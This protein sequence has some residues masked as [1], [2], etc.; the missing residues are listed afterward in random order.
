M[1]YTYPT[2]YSGWNVEEVAAMERVISSEQFTMGPECEALEREFAD[3]HGMKFGIGVNSG[4][5]ANLVAVAA[6]VE[7]DI[8]RPGILSAPALAWSTTYAPFVQ[9]GFDLALVD[10]DSSWNA[11][12]PTDVI[13][14]VLGNP[15]RNVGLPVLCDNCESIG[16]VHADGKLTGTQGLANT[17]SFYFSHQ[18]SAIEGGMILTDNEDIAQMCRMVRNHGWSRGVRVPQTFEDEYSFVAMGY[19]VRPLEM[20]SAIARE[21]LRKLHWRISARS[22][23]Y[24]YWLKSTRD[25]PIVHPE[26]TGKPSFFGLHFCVQSRET[27]ATLARQFRAAGIDCRPPLAGS[28]RR[29]PYGQRWANQGTPYADHVHDTG[30]MIGNPPEFRPDLIDAAAAVMREVL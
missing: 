21:Q 24:D 8:I 27:R 17:F 30:I 23:N 5:S 26:I 12:R 25:L 14:N 28:L 20:H 22:A 9:Y 2:A 1:T 11:C 3:Y 19:N 13:V 16:A 15:A 29:Q 6:L 10:C 7:L 4:S 18:L